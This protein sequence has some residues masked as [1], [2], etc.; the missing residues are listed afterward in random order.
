[1]R[2]PVTLLA[3]RFY[4][5]RTAFFV[6][7][8]RSPFICLTFCAFCYALN[9]FVRLFA[10]ICSTLFV[11]PHS[12]RHAHKTSHPSTPRVFLFARLRHILSHALLRHT[13]HAFF[14]VF[15]FF[16]FK[17]RAEF[18]KNFEILRLKYF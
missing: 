12:I 13:R 1:M 9:A 4:A 7:A 6:C 5:P 18:E 2:P 10:I 16:Y 3:T 17:F 11:C 8:I 14:C 15:C